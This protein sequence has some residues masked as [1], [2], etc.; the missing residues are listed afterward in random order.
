[1]FGE[2]SQPGQ[3]FAPLSA[4]WSLPA[5][6]FYNNGYVPTHWGDAQTRLTRRLAR[7]DKRS[8]GLFLSQRKAKIAARI[9]ALQTQRAQQG[10]PLL[11]PVDA[12]GWA[13]SMQAAQE[14]VTPPM[15]S[16]ALDTYTALESPQVPIWTWVAGGTA[17]AGILLAIS[18]SMKRRK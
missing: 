9:D 1:M 8:W 16:S 15:D 14:G 13:A 12:A 10:L 17:V 5:V 7:L 11:S 2:P 6:Q 4:M 18:V 3:G